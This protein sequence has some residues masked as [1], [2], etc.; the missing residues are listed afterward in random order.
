MLL[1]SL[2]LD[3]KLTLFPLVI[4]FHT[5]LWLKTLHIYCSRIVNWLPVFWLITVLLQNRLITTFG[6]LMV[7][8]TFMW[9][10]PGLLYVW[11]FHIHHIYRVISLSILLYILSRISKGQLIFVI[12]LYPTY[13]AEWNGY[14]I[15]Q[16][17][18]QTVITH[19]DMVWKFIFVLPD[20]KYYY[21]WHKTLHIKAHENNFLALWN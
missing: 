11:H 7:C 18:H 4:A 15:T 9:I 20:I 5:V 14:L 3:F 12:L 8:H 16:K 17:H 21:R 2:L 13:C 10:T 6:L 1:T 19:S